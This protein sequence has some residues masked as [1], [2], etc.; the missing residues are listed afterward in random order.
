M[1]YRTTLADII[2]EQIQCS[3]L[4]VRMYGETAVIRKTL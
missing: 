4:N 1:A 2:E 3:G